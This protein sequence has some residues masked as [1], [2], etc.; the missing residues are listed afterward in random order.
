[1]RRWQTGDKPVDRQTH[2]QTQKHTLSYP[3]IP[4]ARG[5]SVAAIL[6][7]AR[8]VNQVPFPAE[9][10]GSKNREFDEPRGVDFDYETRRTANLAML[11][12]PNRRSS[13]SAVAIQ[14]YIAD[15][16]DAR[17]RRIYTATRSYY[18]R[19]ADSIR[20]RLPNCT[21]WIPNL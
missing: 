13:Y 21:P 3:F 17:R 4:R 11:P 6:L 15:S 5:L 18:P 2:A 1:M 16:R 7:E 10:L 9:G 19:A 14:R 8:I 20:R 12:A